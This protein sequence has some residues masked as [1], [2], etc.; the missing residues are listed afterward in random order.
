MSLLKPL[1]LSMA[2]GA[3]MVSGAFAARPSSD[4]ANALAALADRYYEAQ[5][6]FDPVYSATLVGDNRFD[7]ELPIGI[8][9]AERNKRFAMY[10]RVQKQLEAIPRAGLSAEDALTFDMLALDVRTR[11][12]FRRFKDD[13]LPLQQMDSMPV[14]LATFAGGQA[15]QPLKTVRQYE[16]FLRRIDRLPAWSD[17]A[18]ANMREG[19]RNGVVQPRPVVTAVIAQLRALGS[20]SVEANPFG[21]PIANMPASFSQDDRTRL[22]AAYARALTQDIAPA[23]RRLTAFLEKDYLAASRESVGWSALPEGAAWY[24]QWVRLQTTL[25]LTPDE[26]HMIGEIEVERIQS[27]LGKLG[28]RLGY[29]G[30]P[31]RLLAWVRTNK[32]FLPFHTAAEILDRYGAINARVEASLPRLF[33]HAPKA[34]LGILPEPELTRATASDHYSLPA[35]DGSRPG[36][37]WAVI[38]D[39]A[40]YEATKMTALFLHEGQPGHHFQMALQQEMRL[41]QFRK[42]AWINA[43]GEGWA[44]YAESLGT[45][46]GLYDDPVAYAGELQL[47]IF[48]AA[49]LVVDTGLHAQGWSRQKAVAYLMDTVGF[50]EAQAT[51][52]VDRYLA[53]P[54]QALGYKL[55]SLK[56]QELRERAQRQ[57]GPRFDIAAFHDAVL[58]EGALPLPLLE[59]RIDRWIA[60]TCGCPAPAP[61]NGDGHGRPNLHRRQ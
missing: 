49:R 40:A 16:A 53:W 9:P 33:G 20:D 10:A 21:A 50:S 45:E 3:C 6:R 39:P 28:P 7:A 48:R 4:P 29:D 17:Q 42:R 2:L 24:R 60:D 18:I 31:A 37:F 52:Q 19:I 13:L 54:A 35:E 5:A 47:E 41:P 32:R 12:G 34:A 38:D 30:D 51:N 43:F 22:A 44:L 57:L 36:V 46:I 26:I 55:G 1:F 11:L 25:D 27:E 58:A 61:G 15:E 14:Q 59:S 23:M 8:A 56:I